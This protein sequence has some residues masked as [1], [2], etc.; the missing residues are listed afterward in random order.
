[1]ARSALKLEQADHKI[2]NLTIEE[3]AMYLTKLKSKQYPLAIES[4]ANLED[5][6]ISSILYYQ[7]VKNDLDNFITDLSNFVHVASKD[8][9]VA[10][11][12]G[13]EEN[14]KS[15]AKTGIGTFYATNEAHPVKMSQPQQCVK[16]GVKTLFS[17]SE[18]CSAKM[19]QLLTLSE[20]INRNFNTHVENLLRE[21]HITLTDKSEENIKLL[22]NVTQTKDN[23]LKALENYFIQHPNIK[24]FFN[25]AMYPNDDIKDYLSIFESKYKTKFVMHNLSNTMFQYW[26]LEYLVVQ[27]MHRLSYALQMIY[28]VE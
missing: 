6:S 22:A 2:K 20:T 23:E 25:R 24:E 15:D 8:E 5:V 14:E 7:A 10:K 11:E 26:V 4:I 27:C 28:L 1:M 12:L 16:T 18:V 17:S 9:Q 19:N 21:H 3:K 13:C